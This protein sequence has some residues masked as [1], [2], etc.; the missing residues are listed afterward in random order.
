MSAAVSVGAILTGFV[1]TALAILAALPNDSMMGRIR[2]SGYI[3]ELVPH[4]AQALY[5]CLAFSVLSLCAFF[6]MKDNAQLSTY[7][8]TSW[9]MIGIFSSFAFVRVVSTLMRILRLP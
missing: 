4:L 3:N 6:P 7:W 1:A 5:G 2:N 8:T 9:V